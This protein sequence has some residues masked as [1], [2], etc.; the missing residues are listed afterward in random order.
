MYASNNQSTATKPVSSTLRDEISYENAAKSIGQI[1]VVEY[2]KGTFPAQLHCG[3]LHG[4][5]G[6]FQNGNSRRNT[7]RERDLRH[8]RVLAQ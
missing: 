3:M 6:L 1:G 5:C 4:R 7:P 2:N 8:V